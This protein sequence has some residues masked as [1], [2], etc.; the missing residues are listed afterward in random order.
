MVS[1]AIRSSSVSCETWQEGR[2]K[3][4]RYGRV[5]RRESE[6]GA[7]ALATEITEKDGGVRRREA[8]GRDLAVETLDSLGLHLERHVCGLC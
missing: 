1:R 7:D 2:M 5:E 4:A 6:E 3:G 8:R